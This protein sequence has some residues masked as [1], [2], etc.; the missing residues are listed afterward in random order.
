MVITKKMEVIHFK[1]G[2]YQKL[3]W[4]KWNSN[5]KLMENVKIV[6]MFRHNQNQL[7]RLNKIMKEL[8]MEFKLLRMERLMW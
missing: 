5:K 2:K 4:L 8:E 1:M 3:N 6:K 7:M